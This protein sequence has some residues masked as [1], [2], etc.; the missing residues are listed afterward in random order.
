[1]PVPSY[2]PYH[3]R[4]LSREAAV[5]VCAAVGGTLFTLLGVPAAW[6]SGSMLIVSVLG[7]TRPLPDL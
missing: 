1:M 5:I 4:I 7:I 2:I 3:L 6:L